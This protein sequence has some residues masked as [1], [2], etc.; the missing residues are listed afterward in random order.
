MADATHCRVTYP[1]GGI[2]AGGA[3]WSTRHIVLGRFG[4]YFQFLQYSFFHSTD[5]N[6]IQRNNL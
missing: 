5:N 1:I 3:A 2:A 6:P 4:Q